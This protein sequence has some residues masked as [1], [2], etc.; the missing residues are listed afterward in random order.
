MLRTIIVILRIGLHIR[1][2]LG[3]LRLGWLKLAYVNFTY[4]HVRLTFVTTLIFEIAQA[5]SSAG[6]RLQACF[7]GPEKL[8]GQTFRESSCQ[9]YQRKQTIE[10]KQTNY[11]QRK[12]TIERKQTISGNKLLSSCQWYSRKQTIVVFLHHM[13][14]YIYIYIY[15]YIYTHVCIHIYIYAYVCVYAY[16]YIYMHI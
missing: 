15:V 10:R 13:C 14:V 12:Q 7:T 5:P 8:G 1:N 16:V 11:D 6:S 2:L 4:S 3:W 9:W